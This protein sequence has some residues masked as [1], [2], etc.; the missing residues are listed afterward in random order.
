LAGWLADWLALVHSASSSLLS[1]SVLCCPLG[2]LLEVFRHFSTHLAFNNSFLAL[3]FDSARGAKK[4]G[5]K[6]RR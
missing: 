3:S 5:E 4:I 1:S 2:G 6:E